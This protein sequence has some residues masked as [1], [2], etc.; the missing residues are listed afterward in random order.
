M[1]IEYLNETCNCMPIDPGRVAA[2][3]AGGSLALQT[4][5][6]QRP[7]MFAGSPVFLSPA[8]L[9]DMQAQV[10]SI[11]KILY[12]PDFEE[13]LFNRCNDQHSELAQPICRGESTPGLFMGYDFHMTREGPRLIEINTN[14]GG[15]FIVHNLYN[16]LSDMPVCGE[17]WGGA[18]D[19]AWMFTMVIKEWQH[20]GRHGIP[21]T[22]AIVDEAPQT[23][24]L[25]PDFVL[26]QQY[27]EDYGIQVYVADPA[28]MNFHN[29]SLTLD[30]EVIDLVYNRLTDFYFT[31]PAQRVLRN[32]WTS[33]AVV[34]SPSPEHHARFADKRNLALLTTQPYLLRE[35]LSGADP[36]LSTIP[37]TWIVT[38]DNSAE[39]W[40]NRKGLFFKPADGFAGRGA[41]RGAKMTRR[42]WSDILQLKDG[43][44]VAQEQV[45]APSRWIDASG[46]ALKY[47]VRAFTYDGEIKLLAARVYQ[48]QTTNFRTPGGGFA[49]VVLLGNDTSK[50]L[51]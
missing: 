49:P 37:R 30:G 39:L 27:F 28:E 4:S 23:Q 3:I 14:A 15:A 11:E 6:A 51:L 46:K 45:Q 7:V 26:A 10:S 36:V 21:Q 32:A 35:P 24:F 25:H 18:S 47:D 8:D 16:S 12:T 22:L 13:L 1:N 48:G 41:Y 5:L 9:S 33:N 42:V 20:A 34:V 43:S 50:S 2:T 29:G 44:Y 38:A 40:Q 17:K 19:P 31:Q